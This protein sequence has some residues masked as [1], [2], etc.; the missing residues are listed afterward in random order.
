MHEAKLFD[1]LIAIIMT[2]ALTISHASRSLYIEKAVSRADVSVTLVSV[3]LVLAKRAASGVA[4]NSRS[5]SKVRTAY[6]TAPGK[7]DTVIALYS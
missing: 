7:I 3:A 4:S 6:V 5:V 1:I 2:I